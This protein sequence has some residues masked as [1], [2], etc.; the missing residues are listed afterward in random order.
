M[1]LVGDMGSQMDE[2]MQSFLRT[3]VREGLKNAA[4]GLSA[5]VGDKMTFTSPCIELT[6][7]ED[8]VMAMGRPQA[9]AIGVYLSIEGDLS[10][11]IVLL[12][13][14]QDALGLVDMLMD[15]PQGT[16]QELDEFER[17]AL[18]EIGNLAGARFL[19]SVAALTGYNIRISPPAVM[20]DM[21]GAMLSEIVASVA[22]TQDT[23]LLIGTAFQRSGRQVD[24]V[25][26]V[27]PSFHMLARAL[28]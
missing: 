17:S 25:F 12:L 3:M 18:A 21:V 13:E 26:W 5:F 9:I 19:N 28:T 2:R 8:M 23:A 24:A 11:H 20:E 6:P 10:G 22:V 14:R 16:T 4:Q 15:Q 27:I 1:E 7:I